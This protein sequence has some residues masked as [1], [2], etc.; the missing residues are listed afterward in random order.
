MPK[1][2]SV[3]KLGLKVDDRVVPVVV[4]IHHV[5]N[6]DS[7]EQVCNRHPATSETDTRVCNRAAS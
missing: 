3:I 5:A 2:V 6:D 1:L 4:K 7:G